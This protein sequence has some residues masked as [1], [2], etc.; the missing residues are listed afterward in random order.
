[1]QASVISPLFRKI[2]KKLLRKITPQ[3]AF[4]LG[5]SSI[6]CGRPISSTEACDD[7]LRNNKTI[8]FKTKA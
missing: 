4:E 1:M 5:S 2:L 6:P 7:I 3:P 8:K